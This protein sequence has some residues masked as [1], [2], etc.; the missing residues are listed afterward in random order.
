MFDLEVTISNWRRQMVEA[1]IKPAEAL[2]ELE[3]HLRDEVEHEKR[4]GASNENAFQIAT[5]R[6]GNVGA[7][8]QEFQKVYRTSLALEKLMIG[9]GVIFVGFIILLSALS[10]AVCFTG[11]GERLVASGA[12][13]SIL[14]VACRWRCALPLLPVIRETGWRW[15]IGLACI[16]FGFVAGP[17]FCQ[18]VLPFFEVGPDHMLPGVGLWAV[19]LVAVFFCTGLGFLMSERQR[20]NWG[21]RRSGQRPGKPWAA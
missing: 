2:N 16:G 11:I 19:F 21:I 13:A 3:S 6:L 17:L 8:R 20:E 1:G 18:W 7:L 10:V 4:L 15:T 14:L 9:I 12:V 5:Q